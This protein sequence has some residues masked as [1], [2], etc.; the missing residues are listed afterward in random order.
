VRRL[1]LP[2]GTALAG[3]LA[4]CGAVGGVGPPPAAPDGGAA[5]VPGYRTVAGLPLPGPASRWDYQLLDTRAGRLYLAH[6]GADQVVVVDLA[7]QR[8]VGTVPGIESVQGLA[9]APTLGRLYASASGRNQ[10]AVIDVASGQVVARVPAGEAP[11][12]LVYVSSLGRLFV[13]DA[14]GTAETVID[15]QSNRPLARIELGAGVGNSQYD[16][17]T[18]RLLVAVASRHEL[19]AIDPE[20]S[21]VV[22]RYPLPGCEGAHEVQVDVY[23]QDRAFVA[24]E[25]NAR[26]VGLDLDTGSL[27]AS[28]EV[29]AG[30]DVLS[31]DPGLHRLYVASESGVLTVIDAAGS[32][33]TVLARGTAGPNAHS[34]AVDPDTH[35]V[36]L[37][38]ASVGGR[39]VLRVLAPL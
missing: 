39:S 7:Q 10:V 27:T 12:G 17:W 4:A 25:G 24:C 2:L 11:D 16:P 29:G 14:G 13:S 6:E 37:P 31:L 23:G 22:A 1:T 19:D 30:P 18:G 36:Y 8:V 33:P 15:A 35:L 38:L 26:V 20:T 3:L 34:V 5:T 32:G 9:L 28:L 21:T